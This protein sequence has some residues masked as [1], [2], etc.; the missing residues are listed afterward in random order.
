MIRE[1]RLHGAEGRDWMGF[2]AL[3]LAEGWR[4][5]QNE[6]AFHRQSVGNL[7]LALRRGD[8]VAGFVTAVRH[9][10]SA[11][12][13]N[14]IIA[15]EL[16]GLGLGARLF[17]HACRL[18][19][20]AGVKTLWLTASALGAPLYRQ[21]GFRELGRIERWVRPQGGEGGS[22]PASDNLARQIDASLWGDDRSALLDHLEKSGLWLRGN[23]H[24]LLLQQ[25]AELQ[26]AGPWL[27]P[28]GRIPCTLAVERLVAA[29]VP[30]IELVSDVVADPLLAR[31]MA[32][33]GFS[34]CGETLLMARG[35]V[36]AQFDGI[37]ALATLGSCG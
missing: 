34:A 13:G 16:R 21:R 27:A 18:M 2:L 31:V 11:W 1:V 35:P 8:E 9:R 26:I 6:I 23:N 33:H 3:A 28:A 14:L 19:E 30:G 10:K 7:A 17:D 24:L 20:E 5:P 12:I 37:V 4:V 22:V 29:A 15:A 36:P 25:G 32:Q